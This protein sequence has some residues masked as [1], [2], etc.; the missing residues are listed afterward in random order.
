[1]SDLPTFK[2]PTSFNTI[3]FHINAMRLQLNKLEQQVRDGDMDL[4]PETVGEIRESVHLVSADTEEIWADWQWAEDKATEAHYGKE[5]MD[6]VRSR[7][8]ERK[9][10]I[11]DAGTGAAP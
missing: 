9:R 3:L 8:E 2:I 1:M 6:G 5:F 11:D 10:G 4:W 7:R